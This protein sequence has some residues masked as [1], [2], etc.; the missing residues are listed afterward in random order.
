[1]GQEGAVSQIAVIACDHGCSIQKI[2]PGRRL[3]VW[4]GVGIVSCV[5]ES[6]RDER[7]PTAD[8]SRRKPQCVDKIMIVIDLRVQGIGLR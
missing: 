4:I 3:D 8:S 5:V 6:G 1:M 7:L 2:Y